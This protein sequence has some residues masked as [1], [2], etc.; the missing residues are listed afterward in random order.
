MTP[1]RSSQLTCSG[2][3]DAG[4]CEARCCANFN[5]VR[6]YSCGGTILKLIGLG[7]ARACLVV[8]AALYLLGGIAAVLG[9]FQLRAGPAELAAWLSSNGVS[10]TSLL[11]TGVVYSAVG[12][13]GITAAWVLRR[14]PARGRLLASVF[15]VLVALDIL[16]DFYRKRT[17]GF[18]LEDIV[19][20]ALSGI[21]LLVIGLYLVRSRPRAETP[22]AWR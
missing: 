19:G 12:A 14:S 15:V 10:P 20:A 21:L 6:T 8:L 16:G 22:A 4:R 1:G 18:D 7:V 5:S 13:T 3:A 17:A 9:F 11:G 2:L